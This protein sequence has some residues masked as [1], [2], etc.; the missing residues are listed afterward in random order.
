MYGSSYVVNLYKQ[1][2]L[3]QKNDIFAT[4]TLHNNLSGIDSLTG[5]MRKTG[6]MRTT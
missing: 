4:V 6:L 1:K 3:L 2:V 5:L